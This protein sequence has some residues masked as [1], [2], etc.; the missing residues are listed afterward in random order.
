MTTQ[1]VSKPHVLKVLNTGDRYFKQVRLQ[2]RLEGKW[3]RDAGY[4]PGQYVRVD[5]PS[6]GVLVITCLDTLA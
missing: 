6:P 1:E 3:L 5:N 4:Q 2:V